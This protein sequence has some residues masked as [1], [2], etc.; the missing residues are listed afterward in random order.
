MTALERLDELEAAVEQA[1]QREA[2]VVAGRSRAR[3]EATAALARLD[4][5]LELV[6]AGEVDA[7]EELEGRLRAEARDLADAAREESWGA[8]LAGAARA[9]E[10]AE[11]GRDTFGREHYLELVEEGLA[12][13]LAARDG[14]QAAYDAFQKE[15]ARF[16][17]RDRHHHRLAGF[18]RI[19]PSEL[20][21]LP[22]RGSPDEVRNRFARGI[23][24]PT[25]RS[26]LAVIRA[27]NAEHEDAAA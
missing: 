20:P 1:R 5:H 6:G 7:D 8:R 18:A 24:P 4:A 22:S 14:L 11:R 27:R 3:R 17:R 15:E 21:G 23:E 19:P 9:R 13:D 25:P 10:A 16:A 2:D 26:A 12:A